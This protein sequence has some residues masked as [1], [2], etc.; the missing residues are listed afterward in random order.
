MFQLFKKKSNNENISIPWNVD[1][2]DPLTL[3][4]ISAVRTEFILIWTLG[5]ILAS[6]LSIIIYFEWDLAS[7]K[8][9]IESLQ[10][11]I[12]SKRKFNSE[13]LNLSKN[14]INTS[15]IINKIKLN[16]LPEAD[17][18][19]VL[20][21]VAASK[22]DSVLLTKIECKESISSIQERS[23][24]IESQPVYTIQIDGNT[25]G[26][27]DDESIELVND[28]KSILLDNFILKKLNIDVIIDDVR[29]N[30]SSKLVEF[31]MTISLKL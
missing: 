20:F 25:N 14:F 4:N 9:Y 13:F 6:M 19:E 7:K 27:E 5:I 29:R 23:K 12:S 30:G 21:S 17:L 24:K 16:F 10:Q 28:F 22:P 18:S 8:N 11:F 3:P 26:K 1:F 15:N 2:R 31:G